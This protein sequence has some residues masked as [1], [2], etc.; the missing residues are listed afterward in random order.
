MTLLKIEASYYEVEL[1]RLSSRYRISTRSRC[2]D[3]IIPY[4]QC[5]PLLASYST[6]SGVYIYKSRVKF[7]YEIQSYLSLLYRS[8]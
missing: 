7:N 6:L 2:L 4:G 3:S 5:L 8:K 1:T